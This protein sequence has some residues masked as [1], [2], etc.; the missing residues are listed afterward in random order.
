MTDEGAIIAEFARKQGEKLESSVLG[1][2]SRTSALD[3]SF[4]NRVAGHTLELDEFRT[5]SLTQI[6]VCR[7]A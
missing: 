6:A 4:A 5:E 2:E 3:A 7:D 1:P